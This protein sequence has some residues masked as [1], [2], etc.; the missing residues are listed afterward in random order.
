MLNAEK[1]AEGDATGLL[2]RLRA[3]R[4]K[5]ERDVARR[6]EKSKFWK[7]LVS[8]WNNALEVAKTF[9]VMVGAPSS[10]FS[11][12]AP[13]TVLGLAGV[14]GS[15]LGDA[16]VSAT[17]S[18]LRVGM[19]G[20][21]VMAW[22]TFLKGQGFDPGVIDGTFGEHTRDATIAVQQKAKLAADGVAGR[23]TLLKAASMRLEL[24]EEPA[25]DETSSNFPPQRGFSP[26]VSNTQR[27]AVFGHYDFVPAPRPGNAEAIRILGTWETDNIVSVPIP[28]LRAAL[29]ASAPKTIQFHRFAARQLQDLWA[30]WEKPS[31]SIECWSMTAPSCRV[32]SGEAGR[33]SATMAS[34]ALSTSMN[35]STSSDSARLYLRSRGHHRLEDDVVIDIARLA[36][37]QTALRIDR[38]LSACPTEGGE[39]SE[40]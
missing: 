1:A 30:D 23:E 14:S 37:G 38:S 2:V 39:I 21:R 11:M 3:A 36:A 19:S 10:P 4:E 20:A 27:E 5:Y 33:R 13:A 40:K 16:R 8:R 28:Q 9:P 18:A 22:Q 12:A 24:I 29:G 26:L 6:D 7:G 17:M 15:P 34:E 31:S 35:A 32:S 25:D